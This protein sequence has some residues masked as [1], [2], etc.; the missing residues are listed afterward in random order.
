MKLYLT[1]KIAQLL[2]TILGTVWN[3]RKV[4][5]NKL[6]NSRHFIFSY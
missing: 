6:K 1:Q 5:K 3:V 2:Q 4:S